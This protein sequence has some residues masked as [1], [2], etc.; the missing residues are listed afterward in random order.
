LENYYVN[1]GILTTKGMLIQAKSDLAIRD[2]G[3]SG[4]EADQLNTDPAG[5]ASKAELGTGPEQA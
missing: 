3:A 4:L 1:I 5:P 2:P